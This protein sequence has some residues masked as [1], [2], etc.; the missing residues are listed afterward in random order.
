MSPKNSQIVLICPICNRKG[1]LRKK[2]SKS[3]LPQKNKVVGFYDCLDYLSKL[4]FNNFFHDLRIDEGKDNIPLNNY[5]KYWIF[6]KIPLKKVKEFE[7]NTINNII[8][9]SK[10]KHNI[11]FSKDL[12]ESPHLR[13]IIYFNY[14]EKQL[15]LDETIFLT[16]GKLIRLFS[17]V[18][19]GALKKCCE[20]YHIGIEESFEKEM[21]EG[22]K[23]MFYSISLN[24]DRRNTWD[25]PIGMNPCEEG[26]KLNF[27]LYFPAKYRYYKRCKTCKINYPINDKKSS[28]RRCGHKIYPEKDK[29][30]RNYIKNKDIKIIELENK[31]YQ[32]LT[33][34]LSMMKILKEDYFSNK[35]IKS[36]FQQIFDKTS[37]D[38]QILKMNGKTF[39]SIVHYN[40]E[41][42]CKKKECYISKESDFMNISI[43]LK[44][45]NH[46]MREIVKSE[47]Y[48]IG[49]INI[50]NQF[51]I[52]DLLRQLNF[53]D[54]HILIKIAKD[55]DKCKKVY[56]YQQIV[57]IVSEYSK[58]LGDIKKNMQKF[59]NEPLKLKEELNSITKKI[60]ISSILKKLVP[61]DEVDNFLN[62]TNHAKNTNQKISENTLFKIFPTIGFVIKLQRY[63][64]ENDVVKLDNNSFT[65][66][67]KN[68]SSY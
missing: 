49:K 45:Y 35:I 16:R 68:I 26:L 1:F 21:V 63:L 67:L 5:S 64:I 58:I 34:F 37:K 18:V 40:K 3:K 13:D 52:I 9:K 30:S 62:K 32:Y 20:L 48:G 27:R 15:Q 66:A 50:K 8:I 47:I 36:D 57:K 11:K 54:I 24:I 25:I 53:P 6:Y 65:S 41:T 31:M 4:H 46:V 12:K 19:F 51:K 60:V 56:Q 59:Y 43:K 22:M 23:N 55:L 44:E 39:Y 33:R 17:A 61:L 10:N 42:T 28:C 7:S 2:H 38:I 29:P 14:D